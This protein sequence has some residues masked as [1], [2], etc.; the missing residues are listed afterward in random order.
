MIALLLLQTATESTTAP[1]AAENT[2]A[3]GGTTVTLDPAQM[4]LL[5]Q[6]SQANT[7]SIEV[8]I[9]FVILLLGGL[10]MVYTTLGRG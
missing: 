9:G 10:V 3:Q 2:T 4:D 5:L 6:H 7:Q 1:I 8:Y